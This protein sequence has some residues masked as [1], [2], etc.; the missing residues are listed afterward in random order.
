MISRPSSL[1][2]LRHSAKVTRLFSDEVEAL[3]QKC[4]STTLPAGSLL[5]LPFLP[6][7]T[8]T[9]PSSGAGCLSTSGCLRWRSDL[10]VA[11][12]RSGSTSLSGGAAVAETTTPSP[13]TIRQQN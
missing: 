9:L 6:V 7:H 13:S 1:N 3:E 5:V 10:G 12:L 4:I 8:G 2:S 11:D